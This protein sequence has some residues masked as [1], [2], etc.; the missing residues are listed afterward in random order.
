[1]GAPSVVLNYFFGIVIRTFTV[2]VIHLMLVVSVSCI[3]YNFPH[4]SRITATAS[5]PKRNV[6]EYLATFTLL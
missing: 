1:M 5:M 2:M 3:Y 4:S 6:T